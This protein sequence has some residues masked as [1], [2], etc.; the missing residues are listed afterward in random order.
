MDL[1]IDKYGWFGV[2]HKVSKEGPGND[3]DFFGGQF[4]S[5][6]K[7]GYSPDVFE[8]DWK[9]TSSTFYDVEYGRGK[10]IG[11][12]PINDYRNDE[13]VV[14]NSLQELELAIGKNW[15]SGNHLMDIAYIPDIQAY[16]KDQ[17]INKSLSSSEVYDLFGDLKEGYDDKYLDYWDKTAPLAEAYLNNLDY[18]DLSMGSNNKILT[19]YGYHMNEPYA[20]KAMRAFNSGVIDTTW[21][22]YLVDYNFYRAVAMKDKKRMEKLTSTYFPLY[23]YDIDMTLFI[24]VFWGDFFIGT[25]ELDGYEKF[26]ENICEDK[27]NRIKCKADYKSRFF[28]NYLKMTKKY[29]GNPASEFYYDLAGDIDKYLDW[30]EDFSDNTKFD[31]VYLNYNLCLLLKLHHD[32]SDL[33]DEAEDYLDNLEDLATTG[34]QRKKLE[35]AKRSFAYFGD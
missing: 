19:Y 15:N 4:T 25:G 31:Y 3:L 27:D 6:M 29:A 2:F 33:K 11:V 14:I 13:F 20:Q 7:T 10:I 26:V 8:K 1:T 30:E 17:I 9:E 35:Q 12:Y 5:Y 28:S 24:Q 23:A 34:E 22:D 18:E 16:W 32:H 21:L